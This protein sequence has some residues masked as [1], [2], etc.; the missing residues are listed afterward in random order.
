[1]TVVRYIVRDFQ[2][3][4]IKAG[5]LYLLYFYEMFWLGCAENL[6]QVPQ[7]GHI[8]EL[9]YDRICKNDILKYLKRIC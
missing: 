3:Q 2:Q 1:M 4:I 9:F 5:F 7:K 8:L 6:G